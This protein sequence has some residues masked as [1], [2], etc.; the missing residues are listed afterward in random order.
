MKLATSDGSIHIYT[1]W[2]ISYSD[3]LYNFF[4]LFALI[5][6]FGGRSPAGSSRAC[7]RIDERMEMLRRARSAAKRARY[8]PRNEVWLGAGPN[9]PGPSNAYPYYPTDFDAQAQLRKGMQVAFIGLALLIGL[10][11]IG[12][13]GDGTFYPV[14]GCSAA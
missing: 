11:F 9:G 1:E 5:C 8:A 3:G 13:R 2:R 10:G 7:S 6:I 12:Y 14:R 4:A